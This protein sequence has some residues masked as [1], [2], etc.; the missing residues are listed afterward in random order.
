MQCVGAK[1]MS[2]ALIVGLF[3]QSVTAQSENDLYFDDW[4]EITAADVSALF[5]ALGGQMEEIEG[6]FSNRP[7][8]AD[9]PFQYKRDRKELMDSIVSASV[10]FSKYDSFTFFRRGVP[11]NLSE[12]KFE[13]EVF[14]VCIPTTFTFKSPQ[15]PLYTGFADKIAVIVNYQGP[16]ERSIDTIGLVRCNGGDD[17]G[18]NNW[19]NWQSVE[20]SVPDPDLAERYFNVFS[21]NV[22]ASIEFRIEKDNQIPPSWPIQAKANYLVLETRSS[23]GEENVFFVEFKNGKWVLESKT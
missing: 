22:E 2:F 8:F 4:K 12:Y 15:W 20:I 14:Y 9:N 6:G 16:T 10:D 18:G 23:S 11:A 1:V 13:R 3:P 7:E 5:L 21:E 17:S 19:I